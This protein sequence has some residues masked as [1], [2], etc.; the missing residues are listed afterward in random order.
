MLAFCCCICSLCCSR[1][2]QRG[3]RMRQQ[4]GRK[5]R[6]RNDARS[7]EEGEMLHLI[8]TAPALV[9][10]STLAHFLSNDY[11]AAYFYYRHLTMLVLFAL[12]FR[13]RRA[14]AAA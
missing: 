2:C 5:W 8:N 4:L 13:D 14:S 7:P 6:H 1:A 10:N 11:K 12:F 9:Q 3:A